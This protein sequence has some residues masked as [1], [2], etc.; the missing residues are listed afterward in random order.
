MAM[1]ALQTTHT[2]PQMLREQAQHQAAATAIRQK[3]HGI[4]KPLDW[5]GYY[6]RASRVGLG[7]K[8]LGLSDGAH[9]GVL[10]ENR[11]EWV[12]SQLG[13]GLVGGVTVGVYPTSP[14]N[15]IA[16][17]LSHADVEIVVCEDQEQTDKVLQALDQLPRLKKIVVMEKKG[18]ADT[19]EQAGD[20]VISFEAL[21]QL[22]QSYANPACVD[23][24][25]AAQ[26]PD[27]TALIIYTSGSTGKPKGA[28]I[29]YRNIA[30]MA[31]ATVERL[32]LTPATAHL[33]Y[34]PLCHV[35]EQMLTTFAPV[36]LGSRVDFGESI[37]TVQEDLREVAPSMF[38]GVPRIWEKLHSAINIKMHEA[39]PLRRRFFEWGLEI[40]GQFAHKGPADQS[41]RERLVF[42]FFYV[43]V[44][45]AL[46]NFI[47]LRKL[48]VALTGAAPISPAIVH[49]FR[50]LGVPLIEVYGL[51][52]SSG[53]I[54]GQRL[55]TVVRGTV[56]VPV[57]G[58]EYRLS[59]V[60]ELQVRG[61]VVFKGYYKNPEAT[62]TTRV[63][64]WLHTG[65]VVQEVEGEIKIVDRLKDIM[66]TAGGKNLT[67]SEIEN[68]MKT[69]H[70]IKECVVVADAR[71]F[72]SA[73]IQIDFEAVSQ[74]A[75]S[76]NLAFTHFRSLTESPEVRALIDEQVR[77]GNAKLAEV[78]HIRRFHLL[79][80]ELDHDD[81]EVTATM[82]VRRASIYKTYAAEIEA[83]YR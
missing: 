68:T 67:P 66:I 72:V 27:D 57:L 23:Q 17:V 16:Y 81:G 5:A 47:G 9:V 62:A 77:N 39:G 30:A 44:F 25:L 59:E 60:G 8:A 70:F 2:L 26:Q 19:Q 56:G 63:D 74:W 78:S 20:K 4:W 29:S 35:A 28:M 69:S 52:E 65:D 10:S 45:R 55:G 24:V 49:F 41:L 73:L 75:E 3:E 12:L 18:F 46:Q 51:T 11:I 76:R 43:T 79:T 13:A 7:F 6:Q 58:V 53:M 50:T 42:G 54:M 40:C 80:K 14:T 38:L 31:R 71:K 33:S 48:R 15:E 82:K 1:S 61:D 22:G 83:M 36:Y 64:G 32:E 34:L 21:E 37:R